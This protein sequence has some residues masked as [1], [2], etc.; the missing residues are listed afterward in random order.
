MMNLKFTPKRGVLRALACLLFVTSCGAEMEDKAV[1]EDTLRP[2][3]PPADISLSTGEIQTHS[4]VESAPEVLQHFGLRRVFR[5]ITEAATQRDSEM[6]TTPRQLFRQL[7]ASHRERQARDPDRIPFCDDPLATLSGQTLECPRAEAGMASEPLGLFSPTAVVNRFDLAPQDGAHCGEYRIVYAKTGNFPGRA[8]IIL[9]AALPNPNPAQGLEGCRPVANFW[10]RL[11][12]V[13]DAA[14]RGRRLARFYFAGIEG[15]EP[16]LDPT[17]FG[18][19]RRFRLPDGTRKALRIGQVRTNEFV[20]FPWT[21]REFKLAKSCDDGG[22]D[23]I[24]QPVKTVGTP[25]LNLWS[26]GSNNKYN[27]HFIANIGGL[28]PKGRNVARLSLS[29]S[30]RFDSAESQVSFGVRLLPAGA[31]L[32]EIT[33]E[34]NRRGISN[35]SP[36]EIG[37]RATTQTCAGCHELSNQV[38]MGGRL[39]RWSSS[40][41]FVHIDET[42]RIS[43]AMETV[44]IPQR[45][46]TLSGFLQA[47]VEAGSLTQ[48]HA[49]DTPVMTLGGS[50]TH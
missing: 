35:V 2:L 49:G 38:P 50:S 19:R 17:H 48:D 39:N 45:K 11:S 21:L 20:Q 15:F 29:S 1:T 34:L 26:S 14:I 3:P 16:V 9:E 43:P 31:L 27:Q 23:L 12:N 4:M 33:T 5:A 41:G 13:D 40:L 42:S 28:L 24:A 6:T 7:W 47:P 46:R 32:N 30:R 37:N 18:L 22:C 25:R 44:F 8:F 36:D 10:A